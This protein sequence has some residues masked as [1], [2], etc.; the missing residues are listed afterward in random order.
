MNQNKRSRTEGRSLALPALALFL[1]LFSASPCAMAE[2]GYEFNPIEMKSYQ[3]LQDFVDEMIR[4]N[5]YDRQA[6][7]QNLKSEA[8]I[9]EVQADA[10]VYGS[11]TLTDMACAAWAVVDQ[12]TVLRPVLKSELS[13]PQVSATAKALLSFHLKV[14]LKLGAKPSLCQTKN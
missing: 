12:I 5:N 13:N 10:F 4:N 1:A 11:G 2:P 8:A 9:A 7:W 14:K 6:P 3:I